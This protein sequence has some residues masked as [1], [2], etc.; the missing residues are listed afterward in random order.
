MRIEKCPIRGHNGAEEK[1]DLVV[2]D[3]RGQHAIEHF[4]MSRY[5]HYTQVVQH[6]TSS[7]FEAVAKALM[8]K[9]LINE[10]GLPYKDYDSILNTIGTDDFYLYTDDRMW[11]LIRSSCE[12]TND[13]YSK[14]LWECLSQ[15]KKP[16]HILTLTDIVPKRAQAKD[17]IPTNDSIYLLSLYLIKNTRCD[18]AR[19]IGINPAYIG[20]TESKVHLESIPSHL[21]AEE[22][23][24]D[25]FYDEVRGAI[26][27]V[28]KSRN[29][30]FLGSDNK[31]LINKMVDYTSNTLDIFVVGNVNEKGV[32]EFKKVI[33]Q[34]ARK[35]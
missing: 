22:C 3:I 29:V 21:R 16:T 18:L 13:E 10:D 15:R 31:S 12:K 2:F 20:Y 30:T 11:E 17:S 35:T 34:K 24:I 4:L 26:R 7:A 32:E 33:N 14:C 28:D 25:D 6:K 23:L 9:V 8:Y 19:R 5:F 27:I 1:I